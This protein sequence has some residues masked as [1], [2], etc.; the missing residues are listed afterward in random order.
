MT[1]CLSEQ[2]FQC[3]RVDYLV[4]RWKRVWSGIFQ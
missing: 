4:Q 3:F 1:V 2:M